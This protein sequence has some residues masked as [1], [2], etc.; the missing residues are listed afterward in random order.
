M[1]NVTLKRLLRY[2]F[3]CLVPCAA[4]AFWFCLPEP[5]FQE[6]LSTIV[7]SRDG[8]L[9]GAKIASD[10]QWRFP[11][12]PMV[13]EKFRIALLQ[14][15]D[16][17][18]YSHP[19]VDPLAVLRASALNIFRRKIV[20]GGSTI[21]MQVIRLAR[22]N[23]ERTVFE[24]LKEMILA[25]R[26][27][28]RY[29]KNTILSLY[30]TYAPF[31][32]NVVGLETASWRYFGRS[33]QN[34]SW[35]ETCTLAVLPNNPAMIHPGRNR[36]SLK[37][38][39]DDLMRRLRDADYMTE[40]EFR[41]GWREPLPQKP[42]P[43]PRLAPHLMETLLA[44]EAHPHRFETTL[45]KSLQMAVND[46]V[47]QRSTVLAKQ[48]IRNAAALVIDNATFEVMAY[49]GNS[50]LSNNREAGYAVD[51]IRRP[52]S[53]GSILKPLLFAAMLQS[54]DILP[55]TLVPDLPTQYGGY[56]PENYD[57]MYRGAVPAQTALARSLN[58]PAVRMLKQYGVARFYDVLQHMGM[59]T[60]HRSPDRYGLTL[61]LGGAEGTLWD[62]TSMY[63][64]LAHI[65]KQ[66]GLK[67][68]L[69]YRRPKVLQGEKTDTERSADIYPAGAWLTLN[70]LLEVA[71]PGIEGHWKNF[72]SALRVA[73]KTGT[74][75]GLRDGWAIGSTPRYTVGV[76]V[77]NASGEGRT[78]LTGVGSAAP[79][80]FS[81]FNHLPN[82]EW[83]E[84]PVD[85][86][87]QVE[88]CKDDG[89]LAN[90]L[91][92]SETIW[93][94]E[95]S[96][97]NRVSPFHYLVH[98]DESGSRRVHSQ[99][100]PVREMVHKSWF[101]LP[102]GQEFFYRKHHLDYELLP[103]YRDNCLDWIAGAAER[104]PIGL[105]YPD[106]GT[107]VYIPVDLNGEKEEVVFEA[108]HRNR[109]T[110]LY[111]HLDEDYIGETKTFHQQAL[112]IQLG[113]HRLILVDEQ[114][115]RLERQFEV[116]GKENSMSF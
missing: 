78:D 64:N 82:S 70:A 11:Q 23:P 60:L 6:P 35:A 100:E 72:N 24:K 96:R 108:V 36:D 21:S 116:L 10:E 73:W 37:K 38:R 13:P 62:L 41:L 115:N 85:Q 98:L 81:I 56:M 27:E 109:D 51:I 89:Y 42:L 68:N 7:A 99:C 97:F 53:T 43:L 54:G 104:H 94:P 31:G 14:C 33:A 26:L 9:L 5:L 29:S 91:C 59:T 49:V 65:A 71:R 79:I 111:W 17:R 58:V 66:N 92:E 47:R 4:L 8:D 12:P 22:K 55:T 110:R 46:I 93:I 63:A 45:D 25:L 105:L 3:L 34:L 52:R 87:R 50:S 83:F 69:R 18:F 74:S 40:L 57:R 19:G 67:R 101:V 103:P 95:E 30:A 1:R 88:V 75:Y 106:L 107:K 15:E 2:G 112:N 16:K 28:L 86:M 48:F 44:Q 114:G 84:K 20:S 90:N 39:R 80:M 32:G 76:W 102:P 61:I 113:I 77:G